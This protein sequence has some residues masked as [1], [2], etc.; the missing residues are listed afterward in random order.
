MK[1]KRKAPEMPGSWL[2]RARTALATQPHLLL[3]TVKEVQ[4]LLKGLNP[5]LMLGI[6]MTGA[7]RVNA[8]ATSTDALP[9][10][11]KKRRK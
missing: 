3:F 5:G 2:E 9:Q 7:M 11:P 6:Q 8:P 4:K 10:K 1:R